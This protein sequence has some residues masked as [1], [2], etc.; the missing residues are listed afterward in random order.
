MEKL[1]KLI[2][3]L[4]GIKFVL[5]TTIV[6]VNIFPP[7]HVHVRV[8][9]ISLGCIEEVFF[10]RPT[11]AR[12]ISNLGLVHTMLDKFENATLRAKTEQMFY[13]HTRAF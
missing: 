11:F 13:V 5:L 8:L 2:V 1:R 7:V 12:R 9:L 4:G 3:K 6:I 10:T